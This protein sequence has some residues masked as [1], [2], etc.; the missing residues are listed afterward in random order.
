M[1][2]SEETIDYATVIAY[3]LLSYSLK[4]GL[5]E[6]GEN[7]ETAVPEDLY[8]LY[9]KD[10]FNT[11]SAEQLTKDQKWDALESLMFLKVKRDGRVKGLTSGA[12]RKKSPHSVHRVRTDHVN[13]GCA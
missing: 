8:Q 3:E 6:I 1:G 4:R 7:V 10:T 11:G 2:N 9:T 5:R 12:W 13:N